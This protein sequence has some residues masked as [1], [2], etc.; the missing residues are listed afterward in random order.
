VT[1]LEPS[2]APIGALARVAARSGL[3]AGEVVEA[4]RYAAIPDL[5]LARLLDLEG[6]TDGLARM[7][8]EERIAL[9]AVLGGSRH[10]SQLLRSEPQRWE[11]LREAMAAAPPPLP[12]LPA[13]IRE[14][15]DGED[16]V[17]AAA[18]L[19][20][21]R[22]RAFLQ[23]GARDLWGIAS[24]GET[25]ASITAVAET[26][27]AAATRIARR[28]LEVEYGILELDPGRR[29]RF[30]VL[31]MGKLGG[32]EL[33]YSSDV[34]LVFLHEAEG[35]E[36]SGGRRGALAPRAY[37]TRL[38]ERLVRL[39]SEVT[40]AGFVFR[41]DLRLRP[42]GNNGPLTSSLAATLRY[43]EA[44]GRTWERAALFKAR[45]VGGDLDLGEEALADL[46]PFIYRRTLDFTMISDLE[47]MKARIDQ[48][49][50]QAVRERHVK[51]GPG[52]IRELEFLVQS[53]ALVHGGRDRRLRER[54]TLALLRELV[55]TGHL[56]ES[57]GRALAE[58]Y[59]WLRRVEN[60]L[61]LDDDRQ[62]HSLPQGEEDLRGVARRLA[63]HLEGS[64]P[65]WE[66]APG[67]DELAVFAA[68]HA[69]HTGFVHAAFA[70][71]FRGRRQRTME[72]GDAAARRL[73]D[74]PEGQEAL[75]R[76]G[77]LGF[78]DPG[79]AVEALRRIRDGSSS[80]RPPGAEARRR[81]L[82]L[83]PALL[84]AARRTTSP[85]RA[86]AH[87][88]DFLD[89]VGARQTFIALLS[90][91]PATLAL[92]LNLFATSEYLT[93]ELLAHP[94]LLDTLVRSDLAK[95]SKTPAQFGAELDAQ[96]ASATDLEQRLDVLRRY[97]HDEFLRIGLHDIQG[98][99][100]YAEVSAQLSALA[101]VCLERAHRIALDERVARYGVPADL[102]LVVVAL[103][104][105]GGGELNYHSDLD[106]IF[107][108]GPSGQARTGG[109]APRVGP[110]EFF[111]K[112]AQLLLSTLQ[113]ATREGY[114]YK[115][116]T[117]L[118]PSGRAGALVTSLDGFAQYH[119]RSSAVWERQAL[120]RA[121]PVA[122]SPA[123][124][125]QVA[126]VIEAFVYGRGLSDEERREIA[127]LRGRMERELARE[128]AEHLNLKTGRGGLVDVEF[129]AQ[130][131][132]LM[133]G[134]DHPAVRRRATRDALDALG[135]KGLL[136]AEDHQILTSAHAFFRGLENRLR[137]EGEVPV[138][139]VRRNPVTLSRP[140]RRMGIT[141]SGAQ[142]GEVL[143]ERWRRH[144][145]LVRDAF[146]RLVAPIPSS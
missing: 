39:L 59:G 7:P 145:E 11:E 120:I 40:D 1:A 143:L 4:A 106:L 2:S 29:T 73:V 80:R 128:D 129:I 60:V 135:R 71:L 105:L 101:E 33:N 28:Q 78:T 102:D 97:R 84:G 5:A 45:P 54:N 19:R 83:A 119:A 93:R 20:A 88:A 103:G 9:L 76:L 43:Y 100:H 14:G 58:A 139:R 55:A 12:E 34:D 115:I 64:G 95:V 113:I 122:G 138:E 124:C 67:R 32:G 72:I 90:E 146:E 48:E 36:S 136:S 10:L 21:W 109:E 114:V 99:L 91:N 23:I 108:Y 111:A 16:H 31:G 75:E 27:I 18:A 50:S 62:L 66:R 131:M 63:L 87:L 132:A 144:R 56:P 37:F 52:G 41:V 79:R 92:L 8:R 126:Q 44:F 24:L 51:L 30:A 57:E 42:D 85:D 140:A 104:K 121:R 70:E 35:P 141:E 82:D 25:L 127:R 137:I 49:V 96:L 142:A 46:E 107:V 125:A 38:C 3:A 47:Q 112:V 123:L 13:I 17:A 53:F 133:H 89:R 69:R 68:E 6:L 118:R 110:H 22:Q 77:E 94:E 15:G 61:Q 117:R 81:V 65:I 134:H 26:A 86:L 74:D 116:D 98:E 130:V